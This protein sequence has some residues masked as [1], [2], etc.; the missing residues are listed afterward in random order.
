MVSGSWTLLERNPTMFSR[1]LGVDMAKTTPLLNAALKAFL[2]PVDGIKD[3]I[4]D[5]FERPRPFVSHPQ[6]VPC[7]RWRR[8]LRSRRGIPLG[9]ALPQSSWPIC[10]PSGAPGCLKSAAMAA[11]AGCSAVCITPRMWRPVSV[12]VLQRPTS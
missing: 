7:C 5:R 10:C 4:K 3:Q 8:V 11:T 9:T 6:V 2:K 1:A 12:S